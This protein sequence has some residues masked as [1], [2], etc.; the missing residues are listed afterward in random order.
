MLKVSCVLLV[1]VLCC[2]CTADMIY[3]VNGFKENLL[4]NEGF[5][6]NEEVSTGVTKTH[7]EYN[8]LLQLIVT[9]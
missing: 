9:E 3:D 6:I 4:E 5:G 7:S 8:I 1:A 2:L